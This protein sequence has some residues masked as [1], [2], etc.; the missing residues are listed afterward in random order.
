M[1]FDVLTS[2][3]KGSIERRFAALENLRMFADRP[4]TWLQSQRADVSCSTANIKRICREIFHAEEEEKR[5]AAA[6]MAALS[7]ARGKRKRASR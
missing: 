4:E 7:S 3:M 6:E 2:E 5:V 1:D